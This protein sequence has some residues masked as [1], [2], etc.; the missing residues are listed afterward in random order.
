ME[1]IKLGHFIDEYTV[2]TGVDVILFYI[3]EKE[4][5]I[6]YELLVE[7]DVYHQLENLINKECSDKEV[8]IRGNI[9]PLSEKE[10]I[11]KFRKNDTLENKYSIELVLGEYY[12]LVGQKIKI[13]FKAAK[14]IWN[15]EKDEEIDLMLPTDSTKW[16]YELQRLG[17]CE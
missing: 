7:K 13:Y 9:L 4:K 2:R 16:R 10:V 11:E 8:I 3:L 17:E 1:K 14:I 12:G 5:K 6:K 15:K